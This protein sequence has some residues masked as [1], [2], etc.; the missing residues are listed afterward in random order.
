MNLINDHL[1]VLLRLAAGGQIFIAFLGPMIPRLLNWREAIQRM[2]LLV[3]EVF[4]IHTLFIGLTCGIF[5]ILT[6]VFA[7]DI[8]HPAHDMMRWFAFA[9]G[10][11]WAIRC[12]M[13]WTY[14]SPSHWRGLLDKT[15]AHWALFLGYGAFAITY[16]IA[17]FRK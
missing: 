5:S 9:V 7:Q 1:D 2:P 11:F 15:V 12:V 4:W 6:W 10:L 17:A 13:Q 14:Y 16:L 8:A 3:R